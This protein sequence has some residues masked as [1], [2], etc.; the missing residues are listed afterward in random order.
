M[1]G[2]TAVSVTTHEEITDRPFRENNTL[3][4]F[5]SNFDE[6]WKADF[7]ND[8]PL[9]YSEYG[10]LDGD[11][12]PNWF[13]M[14]WFGKFPFLETATAADPAADPDQDGKSNLQEWKEQTNPLMK[15]PVYSAGYVWNM[16]EIHKSG[17][18]WN[19]ILTPRGARSGTICTSTAR[20]AG[21]CPTA[22]MSAIPSAAPRC[23]T[24]D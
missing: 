4:C 12:L 11:G 6:E 1:F 5:S 13:E 19:R 14:Y 15:Q 10:D 20:S 21:S 7:P 24:P 2:G 23:F 22:G 9:Y 3:A 17:L 16:D 18:S 8:K